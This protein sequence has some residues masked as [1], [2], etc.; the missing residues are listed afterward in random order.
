M[1]ETSCDMLTGIVEIDE[2]FIGGKCKNRDNV[3]NFSEKPKEVVMGMLESGKVYLKHDPNTG[4][5]TLV[6]QIQEHVDPTTRLMTGEFVS[7]VNLYK[8]GYQHDSIKNRTGVYALGDI[9]TQ[10]IENVW[11]H[12]K[13]GIYG[14][15]RIV[16]KKYLQVDVFEYALR[17]ND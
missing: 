2:T 15:Y 4:E 16:S 11:S 6:S 10:G 14:V 3:P 12:L 9:H 1:A 7:Y 8:L 5:W 17:F 13:R